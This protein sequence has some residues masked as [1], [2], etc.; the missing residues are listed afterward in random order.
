MSSLWQEMVKQRL[1]KP[2]KGMWSWDHIEGGS[3]AS[4]PDPK[5]P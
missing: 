3:V 4:V 1:C 5:G 2:L